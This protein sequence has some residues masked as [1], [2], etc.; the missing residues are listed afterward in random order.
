MQKSPLHVDAV[1]G[2]Q[3][4]VCPSMVMAPPGGVI[5]VSSC[6]ELYPSVETRSVPIERERDR[7]RDSSTHLSVTRA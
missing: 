3:A 1:D 4:E 5:A 6:M 2:I 7:E